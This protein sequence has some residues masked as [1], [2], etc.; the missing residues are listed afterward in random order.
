MRILSASRRDKLRAKPLLRAFR[1]LSASDQRKLILVGLAQIFLGVLDLIGIAALGLLAS[2]AFSNQSDLP[3]NNSLDK[4]M[5]LLPI[6]NRSLADQTLTLVIFASF[7]LISKTLLSILFTRRIMFFL[8]RRGAVISAQLISRLLSQ[9]LLFIQKR[10]SQQTIYSVTTGV[11]IATMQV[12][13]VSTVLIGDFALLV[14]LGTGLILIEPFTAF[15]TICLFGGI[16]YFLHSFMD[17]RAGDL[18]RIKSDLTISSSEKI[19]EVIATYRE[20]VV[21]N[22]RSF[23]AKQISNMRLNF[24]EAAAEMNFLPYVSKY[25]IELSIVL[26]GLFIGLAQLFLKDSAS[27]VATLTIFLAAGTRIAPSVLRAQQGLLQIRGSLPQVIATLD[28]YEALYEV[29]A[30][31]SKENQNNFDHHGFI[32]TVELTEVSLTYPDS[33][34]NAVEGLTLKIKPGQ[35]VAIVGPSGAG[36]TSLI[37]LILGVLEPSQGSIKISGAAPLHAVEKWPGAVAYVPQ[38]VSVISGTLRENIAL[39]CHSDQVNDGLVKKAIQ[40]AQLETFVQNLPM[41]LDSQTGER[42]NMLSGGQRQ[43]L[44]IARA[45]YTSPKLLVLDEATSSLDGSTEVDVSKAIQSIGGGHTTIL[46]AHRLST[47]RNA[48]VVIYMSMGRMIAKGTFDEVRKL[49][50]DF[51]RQA[52]LMGI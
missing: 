52:K 17:V 49:V 6:S 22:S 11:E 21:R 47:V 50:P 30:L 14:V 19:G 7:I 24:A 2:L 4:I 12:L 48:D 40:L 35:F 23:Y 10:T 42:G 1:I 9:S 51:D 29:R 44:G 32:P 31:S 43:R 28:L 33:Q 5:S 36:K 45:L 25:V 18:G 16:S 20:S 3:S 37:D 39:G 38:E 13:A 41:G 27:G 26:G 15:M 8:S 34:V 46:I